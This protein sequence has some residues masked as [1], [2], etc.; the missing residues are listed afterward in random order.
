FRS[1]QENLQEF[2][3]YGDGDGVDDTFY[4]DDFDFAMYRGIDAEAEGVELEVSGNI[5]D[6][7][8]V[9]AGYTHLTIE[10]PN[11][12]DAR[13]FIPRNTLKALASWAPAW[14]P[15]LGLGLSARWQD[16][17]YFES[18]FG[19]I[20]QNIYAVFGGYV[21]YAFTNNLNLALNVDNLADKKYLSSVKYEQSWFAQP[22][23]Y[24][25]SL[26]WTY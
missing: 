25:L 21:S 17:V 9:Q 24:S 7:V 15:K 8:S 12:N 19:R 20:E 23:D 6:T 11:G 2:V 16:D 3:E 14:E 13:T 18:A 22:L 1:E 10:D 26:R 4:D 5:T